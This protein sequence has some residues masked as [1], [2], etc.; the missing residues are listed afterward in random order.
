MAVVLDPIVRGSDAGWPTWDFVDIRFNQETGYEAAEVVAG[1][2]SVQVFQRWY[3]HLWYWGEN[4]N[5]GAAPLV[6]ETRVGLTVAGM[7]VIDPPTNLTRGL[8]DW[9]VRSALPVAA[10]ARK[11]A[12]PHPDKV[13][14][15]SLPL[16]AVT[17]TFH[18]HSVLP[19][20]VE[21]LKYLED[22]I[23]A[24]PVTYIQHAAP[25]GR[26]LF[27]VPGSGEIAASSTPEE[28]VEALSRQA[29]HAVTAGAVYR[30]S[31]LTDSLGRL[32]LAFRAATRTHLWDNYPIDLPA[33]LVEAPNT[34]AEYHD[35][36]AAATILLEVM[37]P[38]RLPATPK[39]D[40]VAHSPRGVGGVVCGTRA[41][42]RRRPGSLNPQMS[43][44]SAEFRIP[45]RRQ[46]RGAGSPGGR[47]VGH[48][49][50]RHELSGSLGSRGV[51]AHGRD[52]AV[53]DADRR[54]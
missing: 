1:L 11:Y 34:A 22:L 3:R 37:K 35:H 32:D 15:L 13:V 2:P 10:N 19:P 52:P 36:L 8:S 31:D 28:Y 26:R 6:R 14:D 17:S 45:R 9:Y 38:P 51:Q 30:L 27:A 29:N 54:S 48:P 12:I 42:G 40:Q 43:T 44:R 25:G 4:V 49:P 50:P 41:S 21:T 53:G 16:D 24:E 46:D 47:S 5:P 23:R 33:R 20:T 7:C 39:E 18:D